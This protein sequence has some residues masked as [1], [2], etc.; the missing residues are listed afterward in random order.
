MKSRLA[1]ERSTTWWVG[2]LALG[3]SILLHLWLVRLNPNLMWG[4]RPASPPRTRPLEDV[5]TLAPPP[6]RSWE[7]ELPELLR[8]LESDAEA[9]PEMV[10]DPAVPEDPEGGEFAPEALELD[11]DVAPA[12]VPEPPPETDGDPDTEWRPRQ[13]VMAIAR[14]R[15]EEPLPFLPRRF[16]HLE[17]TRPDAPDVRLPGVEPS[18]GG[19]R[20]ESFAPPDPGAE[21]AGS[22]GISGVPDLDGTVAGGGGEATPPEWEPGLDPPELDPA[23][24]EPEYEA[25]EALLRLQTRVWVDTE[26]SGDRYFKIQL[27]RQGIEALPVMPRQVVFL[28]DCSASMTEEKLQ[29]ALRGVG[30]ALD[31]LG[32]EAVFSIAAF[33][34]GVRLM[35]PEPLPA[36]VVNRARAKAFLSELRAYGQTDVFRSLHTLTEMETR[37]DR[38]ALAMVITDGVSTRGVKDTREILDRFTRQNQGRISVFSLGGGRRVNRLLLDFLSY[39]NRGRSSVTEAPE[40]LPR[41]IVRMTRETGRPVLANLSARFTR[42]DR[43]RVYPKQLGHLYLDMPLVM[44]GRAPADQERIGFQIVGHSVNGAHDMVFE[45]DLTAAP[46][47]TAALRR[48]WGRQVLLEE[49][50]DSREVGEEER[51]RRV[52]GLIDGYGLDVPAAYLET[53]SPSAS[54]P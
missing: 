50:S 47:G 24:E 34:D 22:S 19:R 51:R 44:V 27:Q 29:L 41:S 26:R 31:A 3:V 11:T 30:R 42:G 48:E 7:R 21:I 8:R 14:T 6:E 54:R 32:E 45:V 35:H 33:R 16:R 38:P 53:L 4:T 1:Y 25:V 18:L 46:Q 52:R 12:A 15:V 28:V 36:T 2:A 10:M 49:L 20:S 13:E 43:V 37:R 23:D 9:V 40:A 5:V 17:A 39:R